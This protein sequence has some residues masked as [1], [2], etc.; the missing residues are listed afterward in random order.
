MITD[1][2]LVAAYDFSMA[3][4]NKI[5]D[6]SGNGYTL[7]RSG[8]VMKTKTGVASTGGM[9]QS[10]KVNDQMQGDFS[11]S[12]RFNDYNPIAIGSSLNTIYITAGAGGA[13]VEAFIVNNG[14]IQFDDGIHATM[15]NTGFKRNTPYTV[16]I[17]FNNAAVLT[18]CYVNGEYF[19]SG[20][21]FTPV[22]SRSATIRV[23]NYTLYWR[24]GKLANII[25]LKL[26]SRILSDA[27][28][29][30]YHNSFV[31]TPKINEDFSNYP[32]GTLSN[33]GPWIKRSGAFTI[34]ELAVDDPVLKHLKRGTKYL[35]ATTTYS[36]I[37][38]KSNI[39]YGTWEFDL[40]SVG[41]TTYQIGLMSSNL[42]PWT[43]GYDPNN[44]YGMYFSGGGDD[45]TFLE[46]NTLNP[47]NAPNQKP[48]GSWYTFRITRTLSGVITTYIKGGMYGNNFAKVIGISVGTNP[49][50]DTT[51][52]NSVYFTVR[53]FT[54]ELF[55]NLKIYDGIVL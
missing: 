2:G 16:T 46:S 31:S 3:N 40:Y 54:N 50:T 15:F 27:E 5:V 45:I 36:L 9:W 35:K 41:D 17:T 43:S 19:G 7:T 11:I 30:N 18:K 29:K 21:T 37:G 33:F 44:Q 42:L 52:T 23:G 12:W 53:M 55:A 13:F 39:A 51:Y 49:F 6:L 8:P 34:E 48:L 10:T 25:N 1:Q 47:F 14:N 32:V 26:H 38:L 28:I 24:S 20:T 22:G 4:V